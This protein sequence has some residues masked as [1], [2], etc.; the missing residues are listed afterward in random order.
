MEARV[1]ALSLGEVD[2]DVV[3]AQ[4]AGIIICMRLLFTLVNFLCSYPLHIVSSGNYH[5]KG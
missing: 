1:Y 4:E 3:E 2:E 5:R